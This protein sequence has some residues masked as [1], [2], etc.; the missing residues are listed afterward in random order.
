M[1]GLLLT[2]LAFGSGHRVI[3]SG[4]TVAEIAVELGL[5]ETTLRELNGLVAGVEPAVGT[6][7]MLP[8][9]E[10]VQAKKARVVS[11]TGTGRITPSTGDELALTCGT[12]MEPGTTICTSV[13]SFATIR[14]AEDDAGRIYHDFQVASS[15]CVT[16]VSSGSSPDGRSSLLNISEGSISVT[17]SPDDLGVVSVQTPSSLTTG[18]QG[19]FRVTIEE[20]ASRTEVLTEAQVS[21][22]AAGVEVTLTE[23]Q[24]TRT[25][26]G[27]PPSAPSQL[28]DTGFLIRP[29][30]DTLLVWPDFAW[31]PVER[32]LGY[33]VQI[34][35]SPDFSRILHQTDVPYPEWQP[36]FLLL[37]SDVI[38]L[39]WRVSSF[40]RLGFESVP[41]SAR[42][43]RVPREAP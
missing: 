9:T 18:S 31:T 38:A 4:E 27:E 28:L 36:D 8:E 41:S 22:F 39:W 25:K 21:V 32:A 20:N 24:G 16:I 10:Q 11:V 1:I 35:S 26:L 17:A 23:Q 13:E 2:S 14:L 29:E 43:L 30:N 15:T 34:S 42:R 12:W 19:G 3:R 6:A 37:P 33:R 40:D 5:S 7:L